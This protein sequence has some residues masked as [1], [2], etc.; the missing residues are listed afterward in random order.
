MLNDDG[1]IWRTRFTNALFLQ[2]KLWPNDTDISL[3][4]TPVS[5][6]SKSQHL[7]FE[8]IKYIFN[9]IMQNSLFIENDNEDISTFKKFDND[10]VD[11]FDRPID[12]I[13]GVCLFAKLNAIAG[14][15][16]AIN[17][18]E[19]ESWQG[20]NL[21]FIISESSPEYDL[22]KN[23]QI[24]NPW[25]YDASPRFSNFTTNT[26]TWQELG[27]NINDSNDRFKIIKGGT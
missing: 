16:L 1:L 23:N 3:H 5:D 6:D 20:E 21:R 22:L 11:F 13:V 18:I 2:N 26:L 12:Q 7:T 9:K 10:I 24:T 17:A 8:K 4:M 19:I 15:Y 25:W 27:F 14:E